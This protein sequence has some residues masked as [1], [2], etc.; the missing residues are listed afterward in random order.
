[1]K[2]DNNI[3]AELE[4]KRDEYK[5]KYENYKKL[6]LKEKEEK[7]AKSRDYEL[8]KKERAKNEEKKEGEA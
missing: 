1:L 2:K 5:A 7:E 6:A 8:L 4:R 3:I